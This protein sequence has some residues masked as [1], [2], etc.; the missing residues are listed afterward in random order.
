MA[1]FRDRADA[2]ARLAERLAHLRGQDALVVLGLPRGGVPVA[3]VVAESLG[4]PLDVVV[5][6]KLGAPQHPEYAVGAI[7]EGVRVVDEDAM[8]AMGVSVQEAE[9]VE[10]REREELARRVER[11]RGERPRLDLRGTVAL[12]VDDGIATGAT[13]TA[14]CQVVR[15]LGAS[16]VIV[17]VPVAPPDWE[18][19]LRGVADE[20]VAVE[21]P[22]PYFAV[23]QWYD[24]FDQT[25]DDEVTELLARGR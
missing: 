6:R 2:G 22:S 20:L 3:A 19:R 7:G 23:G 16:R 13:A 21:T 11:F 15:A 9:R 24:R 10:K 18:G 1:L 4:A 17:A 12:I 5:V 8:T 14:A 25:S